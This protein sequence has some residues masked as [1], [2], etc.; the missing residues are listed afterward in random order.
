VR[1]IC[2]AGYYLKKLSGERF[3]QKVTF[4]F[5]RKDPPQN[6]G[7]YFSN[8]QR[9]SEKARNQKIRN[10]KAQVCALGHNHMIR[11]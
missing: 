8:Q 2:W 3:E 7:H 1:Q 4:S 6:Q 10:K 11:G 9:G 5:F